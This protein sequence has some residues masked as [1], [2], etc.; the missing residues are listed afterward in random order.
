M[1]VVR[2]DHVVANPDSVL[3]ST[4]PKFNKRVVYSRLSQNLATIVSAG[5]DEVDRMVRKQ[6]SKAL[7]RGHTFEQEGKTRGHR[8]RLQLLRNRLGNGLDG[9]IRLF[10]VDH[11]R[12]RE[13][14]GRSTGA[15]NQQSAPEAFIED[16]V[17]KL[18]RSQFNANHQAAAANI[19]DRRLPLL[20]ALQFRAQVFAELRGIRDIFFFQEPDC[21]Q[22]GRQTY[23]ISAECRRMSARFPRH[24]FGTSHRYA[25]RHA[26]GNAFGDRH[27]IRMEVEVFEREHLAGAAHTGLDFIRNQENAVLARDLLELRKKIRRRDDVAALTL[28][29]FDEDRRD[30]ARIDGRLEN[31]IL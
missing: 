21:F 20:Q 2:H 29:G 18:A 17:T 4:E 11:Q 14:N 28:N 12:R 7:R 25:E 24:D 13:A 19:D 1:N 3:A 8:P 9:E 23:R 27:D 10:F 5:R 30:F 22:R 15:E 16:R 26:G 31:D 6:P